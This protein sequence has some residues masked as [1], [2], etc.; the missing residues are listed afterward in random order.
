MQLCDHPAALWLTAPTNLYCASLR[1]CVACCIVKMDIHS[2]F[3]SQVGKK[4]E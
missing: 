3:T 4:S 2:F 1:V